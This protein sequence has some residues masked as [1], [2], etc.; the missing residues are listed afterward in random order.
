MEKRNIQKKKKAPCQLLKDYS[1]TS[2]TLLVTLPM[3]MD[4]KLERQIGLL[5]VYG[6]EA[7]ILFPYLNSSFKR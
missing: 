6:K 7:E 2:E 5:I 3:P 1:F 4:V